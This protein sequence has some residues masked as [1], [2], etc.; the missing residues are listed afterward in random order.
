MAAGA[1]PVALLRLGG[2][3]DHDVVVLGDALQQPAGDVEVVADLGHAGR[4]D[5]ELPLA[6][7]HLGV[8]AGDLEAGVDARLGVLLDDV[9][10]EDL[11]GAD[12]AVVRA[13]RVGVAAAV[14]EAERRAV[15][16]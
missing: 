14:G 6:G 8:G 2:E 13:L 11:V 15:G 9:A 3:A 4:A 16:A 1:V 10:A 5:L 7:H 12:A